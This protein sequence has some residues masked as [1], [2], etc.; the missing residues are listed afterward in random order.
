MDGKIELALR[1]VLEQQPTDCRCS[2]CSDELTCRTTVDDD[3]N[4]EITV[5]PCVRCMR[6]AGERGGTPDCL[7]LS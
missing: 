4:I 3:L 6:E 5:D 7:P 1:R 2:E